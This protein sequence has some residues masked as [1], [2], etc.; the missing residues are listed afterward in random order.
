MIVEVDNE[1]IGKVDVDSG[2]F[3]TVCYLAPIK[4]MYK[5]AKVFSFESD[6]ELV[7][8]QQVT[9]KYKDLEGFKMIG[10]NMFVEIVDI[11]DDSSSELEDEEESEDVCAEDDDFIVPDDRSV[12]E[13]PAD[14][15]QV[16]AQWNSWRPTTPGA[17][18]FKDKVDEMEAY[19]NHQ[20]D[21]KYVFKN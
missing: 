15:R 18:R 8:V 21:E 19:M 3:L 1:N 12:M 6:S 10:D 11:D 4:K 9:K 5:G 16:D 20:I 17:K 13:K 14:H 7:E 2:D